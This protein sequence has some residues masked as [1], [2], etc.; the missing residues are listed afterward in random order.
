LRRAR[1]LANCTEERLRL[2]ELVNARRADLE[3]LLADWEQVA[4]AI[5]ANR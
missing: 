5:E 3:A 2:T 4:Q 1:A